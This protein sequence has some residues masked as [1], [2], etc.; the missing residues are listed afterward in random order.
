MKKNEVGII[1]QE[2]LPKNKADF[3]MF[4]AFNF[5]RVK[6][7]FYHTLGKWRQNSGKF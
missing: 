5:Q 7:I 4:I 2:T 6:R 1:N 3:L